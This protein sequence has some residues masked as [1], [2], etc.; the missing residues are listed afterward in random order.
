MKRKQSGRESTE[1]D[2]GRWSCEEM[3]RDVDGE[4]QTRMQDLESER[5]E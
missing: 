2:G 4:D 1:D 5:R 3:K